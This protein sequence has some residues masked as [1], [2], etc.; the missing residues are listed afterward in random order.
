MNKAERTGRE[1]T[2]AVRPKTRTKQNGAARSDTHSPLSG[3]R[4]RGSNPCLPAKFETRAGTSRNIKIHKHFVTESTPSPTRGPFSQ[5]NQDSWVVLLIKFDRPRPNTGRVTFSSTISIRRQLADYRLKVACSPSMGSLN[6][7]R[8]VRNWRVTER[9]TT[10]ENW[11][12]Q[13]DA[14]QLN[15]AHI[16]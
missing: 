2:E 1:P 9:H 5:P 10:S 13:H 4:Y 6:T 15:S 16:R 8:Q 12:A 3:P 14:G 11:L 7:W